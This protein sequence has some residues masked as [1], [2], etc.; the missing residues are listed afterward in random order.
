[1]A[2]LTDRP[3]TALLVFDMQQGGVDGAH[4]RAATVA[5]IAAL[6]DRARDEQVPVVWIRHSAHVRGGRS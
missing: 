4:D 6:I 3:H 2:T 1:M 5:R